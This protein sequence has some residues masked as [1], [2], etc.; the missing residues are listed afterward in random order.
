MCF[1]NGYQLMDSIADKY[2][3]SINNLFMKTNEDGHLKV[4]GHNIKGFHGNV[5]DLI[6]RGKS[7]SNH[8]SKYGSSWV[9][10]HH[11]QPKNTSNLK[12]FWYGGR[13]CP[14]VSY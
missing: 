13:W 6:V 14:Q 5:E 2:N 3:F 8:T 9:F 11:V 1:P 10:K 4:V 7:S 12:W